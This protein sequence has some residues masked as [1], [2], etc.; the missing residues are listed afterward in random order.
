M[1]PGM[2]AGSP[3]L[4]ITGEEWVAAVGLLSVQ[5]G[6][7]GE[8]KAGGSGHEGRHAAVPQLPARGMPSQ[9]AMPCQSTPVWGGAGEGQGLRSVRKEATAFLR[10]CEPAQSHPGPPAQGLPLVADL[11]SGP[12]APPVTKVFLFCGWAALTVDWCIDNAHTLVTPFGSRVWH[13]SCGR[14]IDFIFAAMD[15]STKSLACEIPKKFSDGGPQPQ[16]LRSADHP[17]LP[18]LS[19]RDRDLVEQQVSSSSWKIVTL[20]SLV[21]EV[22]VSSSSWKIATLL[23]KSSL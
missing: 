18:H 6:Q 14:W 11:M 3:R 15:C 8:R 16:P 4:D 17:E 21:R 20:T 9:S 13:S 10:K 5:V 12:N 2:L 22:P 7:A 1:W 23:Y 19:R